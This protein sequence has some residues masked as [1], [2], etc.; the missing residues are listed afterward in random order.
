MPP[1]CVA[2]G[3][4]AVAHTRP[5]ATVTADGLFPVWILSTHLVSSPGRCARSSPSSP[6]AT[7]TAPA[8]A[9]TA[10]GSPPTRHRPRHR[11]RRRVDPGDRPVVAVDH[12]YRAFACRDGARAVADGDR[13][14]HGARPR[15]DPGDRARLLA[16]DP[17]R[18][19]A[20]G[21]RRRVRAEGDRPPSPGHGRARSDRASRRPRMQPTALR[22]RRPRRSGRWR[23]RSAEGPCWCPGRSERRCARR[24]RR[25]RAIPLRTPGREELRRR[26]WSPPRACSRSMREIVPASVLATQIDPPPATTAPG[27]RPTRYSFVIRPPSGS[28]TPT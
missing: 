22:R 3:A 11:V 2:C 16:R 13:P 14:H 10:V 19:R 26:R 9:A 5:S 8:P 7:H 27:P 6:P 20:G 4:T 1:R 21:H 17:E 18:A 25:P 28:I 15:L 24:R 23:C 12:P